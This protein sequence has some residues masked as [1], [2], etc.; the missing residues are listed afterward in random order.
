V[1]ATSISAPGRAEHSPEETRC[2]PAAREKTSPFSGTISGTGHLVK[3]GGN[4]LVLSGQNT[5]TGSTSVGFKEAGVTR[6]GGVSDRHRQHRLGDE[7]VR[8][9]HG[10]QG[11]ARRQRHDLHRRPT[12]G[13]T[14]DAEGKI[15]PKGRSP[16]IL[17]IGSGGFAMLDGSEFEVELDRGVGGPVACNGAGC[18]SQLRVVDG[19]ILE[20]GRLTVVLDSGVAGG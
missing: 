5:Y 16:G 12:R 19:T 11:H 18:Y 1:R 3:L 14:I 10:F 2:S 15:K 9:R 13:V 6:D 7:Q 8:G 20:G 17:T 4:V